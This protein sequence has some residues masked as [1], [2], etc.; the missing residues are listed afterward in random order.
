MKTEIEV[1]FLSLSHDEVRKRL[2]EIGA[3]CVHP[4]RLMKRAIIDF[5]NHRLV[6]GE[7]NAYVRVRDEGDKVTLTY[8]Q[9]N[10]LSVDGAQ[11]IETTVGSFED[12]IAIFIAIGLEVMSFQESKRE[13][14][15]YKGYE[16]VL[17]E[18]PWLNPYIEIEGMSED[19][20][21]LIATELGLQWDKAA[22]GDVMVAYRAQYPHLK[23][24]E[25]VSGLK[26]V[27]F[28]TPAPQFL[29]SA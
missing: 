4:M 27:R 8:K 13:T 28:N 6:Q 23:V 20:L 10:S 14:W 11:E 7:S 3:T 12:A 22:F 24:G 26:E 16:I 2:L 19:G 21:K 5:T 15:E 1:K 17:D 29:I 18:W 9:F 25:S